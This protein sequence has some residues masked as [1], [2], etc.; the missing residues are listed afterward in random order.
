MTALGY[1]IYLGGFHGYIAGSE[2]PILVPEHMVGFSLASAVESSDQ[3]F[4]SREL[5]LEAAA[6]GNAG[7][8]RIALKAAFR[9]AGFKNVGVDNDGAGD[10]G[11]GTMLRANF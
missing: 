1:G 5:A 9:S 2:L 11:P 6:G 8:R 4:E 7:Q 10:F 3:I